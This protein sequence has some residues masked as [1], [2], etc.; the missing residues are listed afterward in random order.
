MAVSPRDGR[1][2]LA[3][4]GADGTLRLWDV[5]ALAPVGPSVSR[6]SGDICCVSM[7]VLPSDGRVVVACGGDHGTLRLWD[8]TAGVAMCAYMCEALLHAVNR[9]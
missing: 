5:G 2:L 4:A 7:A 8:M 1:A 6:G 3:S 9:Q